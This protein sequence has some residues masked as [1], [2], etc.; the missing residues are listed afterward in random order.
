MSN[1]TYRYQPRSPYA[2]YMRFATSNLEAMDNILKV[3]HSAH[4]SETKN[5]ERF[6][7]GI[8]AITPDDWYVD[9]FAHLDEFTAL[10]AG[11][12]IVGLW[13]CVEL[14]REMIMRVG[15]GST[16]ARKAY[17][18]ATFQKYLKSLGITETDIQCSRSVDELRC[19]N[20]S[21]KH[22]QMVSAELARFPRW[23][24]KQGTQLIDLEPHYSRLRPPAELY[25]KDLSMRLDSLWKKTQVADR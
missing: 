17:K 10:A 6:V 22:S 24:L 19:L 18:H 5:L 2:V 13:R 21:I 15:A 20:N 7:A 25:L 1:K 3:A 23:K 8:S 9:D 11:F 12:A 4:D 16:G 14:Y